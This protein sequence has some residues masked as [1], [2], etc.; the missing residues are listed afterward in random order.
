MKFLF[1]PASSPSGSGEIIHAFNI[2]NE[3]KKNIKKS[4][5]MIVLSKNSAFIEKCNTPYF[6][7][8]STPTNHTCEVNNL[9]EEYVPDFTFFIGAGNS[10]Q[11]KESQKSGA[12]TIYISFSREIRERGLRFG[13]INR[14]DYHLVEQFDFLLPKLSILEHLK[15]FIWP[16]A[17]PT[18]IGPIT[19]SRN[20]NISEQ[21]LSELH[22]KSKEYIICTTGSGR[23]MHGIDENFN[24]HIYQA[25]SH[26]SKKYNL[27]VVHFFG[28][29]YPDEIPS[30]TENYICMRFIEPEGLLAILENAKFGVLNGG[31]A[32]QQAISVKLPTLSFPLMPDHS[33]R[34]QVLSQK[35]LTISCEPNYQS[36]ISGFEQLLNTPQINQNLHDFKSING[37]DAILNIVKSKIQTIKE[38]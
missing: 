37:V 11:F 15:L 33:H 5:F 36:L 16:K 29:S 3:L 18:Y 22:L 35:N 34:I 28:Q 8:D 20:P 13:R 30:N 2:I 26:I 38:T 21:L 4:E 7:T 14:I 24:V 23:V 6:L 10:K 25:L 19:P 31:V 12:I 9:I 17:K 27:K 1:I 32:L